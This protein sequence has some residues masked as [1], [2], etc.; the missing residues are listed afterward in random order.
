VESWTHPPNSCG[1]VALE[2]LNVLETFEP[3]SPEAFGPWGVADARW[4]HLGLQ[5]ARLT[6]A[7]RDTYLTD[8][9]AMAP[10]A[11]EKMLSRRHAEELGARIDPTRATPVPGP[12]WLAA[13][14][15][16]YL[17]TA[18]RWGGAVSL[19]E[20]NYQ[21][22]GSGLVD[23][24]TGIAYQNRGSFFS[25]DPRSPNVLAPRKRT[26]HTL[27]P[28]ILFRDGRPWVVH[29]SM[30]GEIQPQVFAQLVSALVDGGLDIATAVAAPRWAAVQEIR[31][32]APVIS[33]LEG[34]MEPAVG[35]ALGA[36]GQRVAWGTA[37]DPAFGH[38]HAIEFCW[39]EAPN[40][41]SRGRTESAV[42]A[43][44]WATAD[45]RSEGLPAAF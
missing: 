34:R 38:E 21:G 36:M 44:Y 6:L 7:D 39:H 30:G 40:P 4:V 1:A 31:R 20:S 33:R 18:D 14:G 41:Q 16:V 32:G 26:F 43:S 23:P 3:P 2:L 15:T 5:A 11:L 37:F 28:G 29:G 25:L 17:A 27:T 19:I 9:E 42:P 8:P 22:F 13:G 12:A 45:P 24:E 10:G 35:E